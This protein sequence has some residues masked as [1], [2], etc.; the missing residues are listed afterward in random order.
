MIFYLIS[1]IFILSFMKGALEL[2]GLSESILQLIIEFLIVLLFTYSLLNVLKNKKFLGPGVII[3]ILLFS[4]IL[5]SFLV[6]NVSITQMI[7]FIRKF[8]IYYLFFYALFNTDLGSI[9]KDKLLKLIIFLFLIQIPASFIK[10]VVLGTQEKIVGIISVQ[11]GSL[12][13]IM[14]LMAISY[15]IANYLELKNMKFIVVIFLFIGIGLIS[16]KMGILFYVMILF[17]TLSYFY[18]NKYSNTLINTIFI[19][20]LFTVSILLV[21]LFMAFVSLN[22]RANPEHQ[23]GGS[24]D[25]EFLMNYI[26]DYQNLDLKGSR[27]EG[28]GRFQAPVVALDRLK[29]GGYFNLL[30]GFGPGDIVKSSYTKYKDPLLQKYNIGYGGRLGLVWILMQIGIIGMV[31]FLLFHFLLF[32]KTWKIYHVE[33]SDKRFNVLALTTV[34]FSLIYFLDFF[35]YSTQMIKTPG[36][37]IT[38]YFVIYYILSNTNNFE[39]KT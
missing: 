38:Y 9:Q 37:A 23:V 1:L 36:M 7:L 11:E 3:N 5:F 31:L 22:P 34:G 14:P 6:N 30:F 16:N 17:I 4:I 2:L 21:F 27:V 39:E 35:T 18:S 19:R 29:E 25:I 13:T 15:L 12:A 26:E 32:K 24:I 8:G 28:D 20:K 10:L 33:S